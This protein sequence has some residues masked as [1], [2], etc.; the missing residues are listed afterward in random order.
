[1]KIAALILAT[2]SIVAAAQEATIIGTMRNKGNGLITFTSVKGSCPDNQRVVYIR[3]EGGKVEI[4]GCFSLVDD[5]LFVLWKDGDLYTYPVEAIS[6]TP[7][8]LRNSD[9]NRGG[10]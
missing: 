4:T 8:F 2:L 6:F 5:Q 10:I 7:E 9:K 1:M 3:N